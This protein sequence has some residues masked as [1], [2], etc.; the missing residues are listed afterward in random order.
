MIC[1]HHIGR[2]T[3]TQLIRSLISQNKYEIRCPYPD[4]NDMTCNALWDFK[5]C[6]KV[7]VFTEEQV[8]E[9]EDE[10]SLNW[11]KQFSKKCPNPRCG[12]Q[13]CKLDLVSNRV[14]CPA[15]KIND[16]CYMC[17]QSWKS[18]GMK[19]C[20]NEECKFLSD[21][22]TNSP[23]NRKFTLKDP[24]GKIQDYMTP[25]YRACPHCYLIIQHRAACKHMTCRSCATQ[26]C[27]VCL[28]VR[29]IEGFK[30]GD[31]NQYCG[32]VAQV[33]KI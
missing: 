28:G 4:E 27:W 17:L 12:Q 10:L 19:H 1:N 20:G 9:F 29:K 30:C 7:G 31:W 16:F 5:A 13:I 24:Q 23:W 15:C 21:Y 18:L 11:I 6:R 2:D 25:Q 33:Q 22:L 8:K 32:K 26:F 14:V 3:M